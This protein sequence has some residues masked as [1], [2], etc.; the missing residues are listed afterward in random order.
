MCGI[1]LR[2]RCAAALLG[3]ALL[4]S[5]F[6]SA[7]DPRASAAQA[8]ARQFL[9]LTDRGDVKSSWNA[10]GKQFRNGITAVQ[11][12]NALAQVRAPVGEVV[13]RALVSTE[14]LRT[15]PG[16]ASEGDYVIL[17]YRTSFAKLTGARESL[18]LEREADGAWRVIGYVIR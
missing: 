6:A 16:V 10:A 9:L 2:T 12:T 7:Q 8:V 4:L 14:F 1:S 15:F 18:T 13:D 11:W 17:E 3:A 5:G